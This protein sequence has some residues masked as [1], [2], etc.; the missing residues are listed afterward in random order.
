MALHSAQT[1]TEYLLMLGGVIAVVVVVSVL[2][3]NVISTNQGGVGTSWNPFDTYWQHVN[4][5]NP[6]TSKP[7]TGVATFTVN[8]DLKEAAQDVNF[9]LYDNSSGNCLCRA[10]LGAKAAS[11]SYSWASNAS[12]PNNLLSCSDQSC[13]NSCSNT[14]TCTGSCTFTAGT[15]YDLK[16]SAQYSDFRSDIDTEKKA[17]KR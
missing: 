16:I 17:Y 9:L 1:S 5:T 11:G 14:C 12:S 2:A 3:L 10:Q 13:T 15:Y 7:T 8:Y 6:T 4:I